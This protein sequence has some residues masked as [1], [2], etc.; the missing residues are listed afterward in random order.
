MDSPVTPADRAMPL[1]P[2]APARAVSPHPAL[3]E[4][5]EHPQDRAQTLG[6]LFDSSAAH[7][8]WINHVL[9]FG[10][11][12]WYRARA[13]RTAGLKPGMRIID[14][15]CGTGV[16]S[17][18]AAKIVGDPSLVISIDPSEGMRA[19]AKRRRNINALAGDA[20]HLP[21]ENASA[22]MVVMGYALRHVT[23]LVA[24][25]TEFARVLKPGGR[26]LILEITS[27]RGR[28]R[29]GL[30]RFYFRGLIPLIMRIFSRSKDA[31]KLMQYHWDSIE[32]CVPPETI[33]QAMNDAGLSSIH[34]R[35]DVGVFSAY[36]AAK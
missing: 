35:V 32:R 29:R 9:S 2:K 13:L 16:I 18:R 33:Q 34:R 27:P 19:Q 22:D 10:T 8:D 3:K 5:Y 17:E 6:Q 20:E 26:V 25:F 1:D 31:K 23:D 24:A 28:I 14:V 36:T 11:G 4:F 7:Y 30:A 15:A 12:N 21:V